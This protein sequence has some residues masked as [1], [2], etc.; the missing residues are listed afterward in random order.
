VVRLPGAIVG[1]ALYVW[2]T[3]WPGI[4]VGVL[5]LILVITMMGANPLTWPVTL[6]LGVVVAS[7]CLWVLR[8]ILVVAAWSLV[9]VLMF[10]ASVSGLIVWGDR[11]LRLWEIL[12][13]VSGGE[14]S[15]TG[16]LRKDGR[17]ARFVK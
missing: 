5:S 4:T 9:G 2:R 11:A 1:T 8:W 17:R 15:P 3:G 12:G 10:I 16:G 7:L 13:S 14:R 6:L